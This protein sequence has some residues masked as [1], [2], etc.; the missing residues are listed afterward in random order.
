MIRLTTGWD[1]DENEMKTRARDIADLVRD[2]NLREGMTPEDE[3]LPKGFY[4]ETGVE[5]PLTPEALEIMLGEYYRLR[6]WAKNDS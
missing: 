3:R 2:L 6:G 5:N 1:L 4:R